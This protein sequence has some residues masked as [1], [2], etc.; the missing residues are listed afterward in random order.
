M[1]ENTLETKGKEVPRP[2]AAAMDVDKAAADET[3]ED[4]FAKE[5]AAR[6]RDL[7]KQVEDFVEGE[8]DLD[9]ARFAEYVALS[10]ALPVWCVSE[11]FIVP[12]Q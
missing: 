12:F 10:P 3:D 7:A 2:P 6:L 8:G 11:P 1:L 4:R 5:Q 9:G